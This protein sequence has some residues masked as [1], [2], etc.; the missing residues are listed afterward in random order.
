MSKL[1]EFDLMLC[2]YVRSNLRNHLGDRDLA[3]CLGQLGDGFR[4][5]FGIKFTVI[6]VNESVPIVGSGDAQVDSAK[7][8]LPRRPASS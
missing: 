7:R 1:H 2:D 4:D 5:Y 3:Q 8:S 6:P